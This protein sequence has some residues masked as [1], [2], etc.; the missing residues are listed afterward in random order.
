MGF[1]LDGRELIAFRGYDNNAVTPINRRTGEQIGATIYNK[2]TL[3][4]RYPV[5]LNPQAT[6]YGLAFAEAANSWAGFREYNPTE[7]LRS[8]GVGVRVFLPMVGLLGVDYGYGFD[9]NPYDPFGQRKKGQFH[10][11][12]GQQF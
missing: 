2:Y 12:I 6:I 8:A 3:E 7:V 10:F 5:S 1:N 4:L 11:F 9:P